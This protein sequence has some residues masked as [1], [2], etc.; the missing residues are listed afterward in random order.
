MSIFAHEWEHIIVG[1]I[2][3]G[4][5]YPDPHNGFRGYSEQGPADRHKPV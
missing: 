4:F 3:A 1:G 5:Y 2:S